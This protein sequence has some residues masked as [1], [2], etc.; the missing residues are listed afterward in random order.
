MPALSQQ[1]LTAYADHLDADEAWMDEIRRTFTGEWA[2]DVRY[3]SRAHGEPGT[4]LAAAYERYLSTRAAWEG[5]LPENE[6]SAA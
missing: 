6:R 4:S 5:F 2:G 1:A 3:T